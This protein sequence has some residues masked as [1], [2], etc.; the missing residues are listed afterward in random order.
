M[1]IKTIFY[2]TVRIDIETKLCLTKK[3]GRMDIFLNPT[4]PLCTNEAKEVKCLRKD[5]FLQQSFSCIKY[6]FLEKTFDV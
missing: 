1:A 4:V 2:I 3:L 6:M 5:S